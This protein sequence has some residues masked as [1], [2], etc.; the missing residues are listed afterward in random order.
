MAMTIEQANKIVAEVFKENN[1]R[2][3]LEEAAAMMAVTDGAEPQ[4]VGQ[5]NMEAFERNVTAYVAD[6]L[7]LKV[8]NAI[9]QTSKKQ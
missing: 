4:V 6:A 2:N 5:I 1:F 9:Y 3:V 8:A 7:A